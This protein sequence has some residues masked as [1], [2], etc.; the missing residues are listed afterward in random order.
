[1]ALDDLRRLSI[2]CSH[3]DHWPARRE[4]PVELAGD[5]QAFKLRTQG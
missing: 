1:M 4:D 5:N 2:S 3:R